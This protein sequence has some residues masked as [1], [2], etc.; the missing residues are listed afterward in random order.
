MVND[1]PLSL[2]LSVLDDIKV[3]KQE[4]SAHLLGLLFVI[5]T[6]GIMTTVI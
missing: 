2:G 5:S 4:R 3:T 1:N 6:Y